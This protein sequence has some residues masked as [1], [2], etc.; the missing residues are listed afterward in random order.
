LNV[1]KT[2]FCG[3]CANRLPAQ[4]PA[5]H[6]GGYVLGAALR[7]ETA[8]TRALVLALKFHNA[9]P[10]GRELGKLVYEYLSSLDFC[11]EKE[12]AAIVPIPLGF[13]R[14][15]QRGFNQ[16]E[17]IAA[18]IAARSG[19]PLRTDMLCRARETTPQ[20]QARGLAARS[21]NLRGAF[22]ADP[23]KLVGLRTIYLVDDV[24]TSGATLAAAVEALRAAGHA[25]VWALVAA[26]T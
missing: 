24:R 18:E 14:Q 25:R 9:R 23:A 20:S 17:I 19:V 8:A 16:A 13:W 15:R 4:A 26:H 12:Q 2:L 7:Y 22:G 11:F 10:A 1:E 5:C 21:V 6:P 3:V